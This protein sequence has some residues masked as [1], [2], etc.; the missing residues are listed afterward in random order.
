[1]RCAKNL[2]PGENVPA[3][4]VPI[5]EF[6]QVRVGP[7][8]LPYAKVLRVLEGKHDMQTLALLGLFG[9]RLRRLT[10][11][12]IL[13]RQ[14][15]TEKEYQ[16]FLM[17]TGGKHDKWC[18]PQEPRAQKLS[19]H[20]NERGASGLQGPVEFVDWWDAYAFCSWRGKRLPTGDELE[21]TYRGD[22]TTLYPW[23]DSFNEE[24]LIDH[25]P[26]ANVDHM[27]MSIGE[28]TSDV[29]RSPILP[30]IFDRTDMRAVIGE[31]AGV[32]FAVPLFAI[33]YYRHITSP[34]KTEDISFRCAL[35]FREPLVNDIMRKTGLSGV[36]DKSLVE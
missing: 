8:D 14:L 28:W 18:H 11:H 5:E 25:K 23:G 7:P 19:H 1:V 33:S 31:R 20:K 35:D 6:S 36:S 15:V 34:D 3:G 2:Q 21:I 24:K 10:I 22:S 27:R 30:S 13:D 29:V 9:S 4:M 32:E 17:S 26:L 16:D 12:F